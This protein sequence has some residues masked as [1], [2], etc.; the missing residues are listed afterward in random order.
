MRARQP[1]CSVVCF[2]LAGL[3]ASPAAA[4]T[5][6]PYPLPA[7]S[8]WAPSGCTDVPYADATTPPGVVWANLHGNGINSD[9]VT[10][11]LAPVFHEAWT[12]EPATYNVTGPVFD[13]AG[14]LYFAPLQP[15]E[16]VVLISLD[17]GT[18][19]RRFAIPGTG[20]PPGGSAPL[21][22]RDPEMPAREIV[23]LALRDRVLAVR[24]DGSI[25]W[26]VPS[27]LAILPDE[28]GNG[29]LGTSYLPSLDAIVGLA[30]DGQ[31]YAV[32]R[33]T[34][35][36]LLNAP[37]SLPGEPTPP[38]APLALPPATIAAAEDALQV[39]V[40]VPDGALQALISTLRG[41]G[42]EVGNMFAL[43]PRTGRLWVAA[44]APDAED[45]AIDG[46]SEL[47]A[48]YRLELVPSG[49]GHDIVEV[50]HRSFA[51]GTASTPTLSADGS[52]IYLGDNFGKLLA[53]K[54]DCSDAWELDL[55]AQIFGSVSVPGE[56]HEI[57][58]SSAGSWCGPRRSTRSRTSPQ[59][60]RTSTSTSSRR[61]RTVWRSRLVPGSSPAQHFRRW[62]ASVSWTARPARSAASPPAAK[63]RSRS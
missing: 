23:Y 5:V 47:G 21:I 28:L 7:V 46:V 13:S 57:F 11:A 14:N 45:G 50:C 1:L 52:R 59:A 27:G 61:Q 41:N 19:A 38:G 58:A 3:P 55:G 2:L 60:N 10:H 29:V 15:Y 12:V 37:F 35:A 16:N 62:W 9:A 39:M 56:N 8:T 26:D 22:L 34:G 36:P 4:Q 51:G 20:A 40:D 53:I 25:V 42:V 49:A 6:K 48:L 17:P 44:T 63:R 43:D 18:G 33:Q 31:I 54:D 24:T 32:A 30:K